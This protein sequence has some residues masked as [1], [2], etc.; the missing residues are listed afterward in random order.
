M[1]RMRQFCHG[2]YLTT[3]YDAGELRIVRW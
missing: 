1:Y 2:L 3:L